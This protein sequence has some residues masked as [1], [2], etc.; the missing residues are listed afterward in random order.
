MPGMVLGI[1]MCVKAP[2]V[3]ESLVIKVLE[4]EDKSEFEF[5]LSLIYDLGWG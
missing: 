4:S 2:S 5:W 3:T 1:Y